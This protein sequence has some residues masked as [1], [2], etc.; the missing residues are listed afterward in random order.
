MDRT[1]QEKYPFRYV[2][3]S[4]YGLTNTVA[5]LVMM[6]LGILLPAISE[7]MNLS[8]TKQG[9]LGSSTLLA[10]LLLALPTSLIFSRFNAKTLTTLTSL[11]GVGFTLMQGWAPVF[12]VLILGRVMFGLS[13]IARE[14]ARAL[15]TAQWVPRKEIGLV[16]SLINTAVWLSDSMALVLTPFVLLW[17]DDSW[18]G[19]FTA[20]AIAYFVVTIL[21]MGI[22][23]ERKT[24]EYRRWEESEIKR[25]TLRHVLSY[26]DLWLIGFGYIGIEVGFF[27]LI[28]FWPTLMLEEYGVPLTTSGALQ[29]IYPLVAAVAGILVSI[30]L[31]KRDVR[32]PLLILCGIILP[33]TSVGMLLTG[34]VLLL[35]VLWILHGIG[36]AFIP[37]L[38]TIPFELPGIK[39]REIAAA[40]GFI[41]SSMWTGG[42]IG[43]IL[44]GILQDVTG[45]LRLALVVASLCSFSLVITGFSLSPHRMRQQVAREKSS[46]A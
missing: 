44:A 4:A 8:P 34:D 30:Y 38:F 28:T 15:L 24:S 31:V 1:T 16:N 10:N 7:D 45:D 43:P 11:A 2:V 19:T 9:W 42:A 17:L 27:A 14:P 37:I 26:R 23:R 39:P 41:Q 35:A 3:L 18:R 29:S 12:L 22:G 36:W 5:W 46:I 6:S 20:F 13:M 33:T 25:D 21:W 40:M 32:R